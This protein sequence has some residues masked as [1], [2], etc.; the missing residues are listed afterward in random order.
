MEITIDITP[1]LASR[2]RAE[3][4]KRGL[5]T[6]GYIANA[7]EEWLHQAQRQPH[8]SASEAA[9]LEKIDRGLPQETW[10]RYNELIEKRKA[11]TL[12][13]D[14]HATLIA[15]SDQIEEANACRIEYLVQLAQIREMPLE[16]LMQE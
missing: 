5:D 7:L 10:Q 4:A 12:T 3:V 13:A 6:S 11:E 2:L 9:L 14:E 16:K 15:I 8:L 1:E